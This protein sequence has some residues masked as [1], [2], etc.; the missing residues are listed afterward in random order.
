MP[1]AP[2][3]APD[4]YRFEPV[5]EPRISPDG[6]H[7]VYGQQRVDR[8]TQKAYVN[9][10]VVPTS[11]GPARRFT[12][13][14]QRDT[15]PRW[16]PDG[17]TIAFLS[18]RGGS[19]RLHLIPFDG[20]EARPLGTW[21]GALGAFEWSP[22]G[23]RLAVTVRPPA[24]DEAED[25]ARKALG[26]V[27]RHVT[28]MRYKGDGEG[29]VPAE[30]WGLWVVDARTGR[31]RRVLDGPYDVGAPAWHPDGRRVVFAANR[32]PQ[33]DLAPER[34]TLWIV[35]VDGPEGSE[36][37]EIATP[38]GSV[39]SPAISP[40]GT[41]VAWFG[42]LG[43]AEWWRNTHVWS[44]LLDGGEPY[45]A[46]AG[47]DRDAGLDVNGDA[48]YGPLVTGP[49]FSPDGTEILCQVGAAGRTGLWAF[50]A[51]GG[52]GRPIVDEPGMVGPFSLDAAG[53]RVAWLHTTATDP[54]QVRTRRLDRAADAART[55]TRA[56]RW[57]S[58][59]ALGGIE[60]TWCESPDG[61][62]IHGWVMTPP[63]AEP[64]RRYPGL[65]YIHGGPWT[66][67]GERFMHEFH[68]LAGKGYVVGYCNPR[69][70]SGYGEDHARAIHDDWGNRD[71][72]DVLAF[73]DHLAGR[74]DVDPER[75]G[76]TGG[77]YGGYL[78]NWIIG[79]T[80][81]FRAAVTQRSV[82]N[83]VSFWGSSDIGWL[84]TR[85]FAAKPPWE[86]FA[87]LWRQ[88]PIA[89]IAGAR[90]PTLVIH[91]EQDLR[92]D[93]EQGVQ[94]YWALKTLGVE[95]ELVLFPEESHG[96]SRGGRT[97]RRIA[98]LEHIARWFD[99]HLKEA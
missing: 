56:N 95:T 2:L 41:R 37:R 5:G 27:A 74:A 91:S 20:G 44:A 65:L 98:R 82:S 68:V 85:P 69:G 30:R 34:T 83:L 46:M 33:D 17:R 40:D 81:R 23:R 97:D 4:L 19:Q 10:F 22:D 52:A 39:S 60:A 3:T 59:R 24:T 78:T 49:A 66:Q 13:G 87:N 62:R 67:Y 58:R 71:Y 63:G 16:S 48:T 29:Y 75:L 14:D 93:K 86:D 35:D 72:Q 54:G 36:P 21:R 42:Q 76:V 57:L 53:R 7:V 1:N 47:D 38:L 15:R 11:G 89:W 61:T 45:D 25:P 6:R 32:D 28:R 90:T 43:A 96:L 94:V 92:C 99:R 84:F 51:G 12:C 50:P 18:D 79:H 88:S 8:T 9:L 77:S 31:T 73:A 55:I 26:T 70:G 64:G 80:D